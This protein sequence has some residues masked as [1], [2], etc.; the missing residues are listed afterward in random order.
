M[1]ISTNYA[2]PVQV[3]GYSCRNCT[4]VAY[5]KRGV[6]P[7]HPKSGPYGVN[8]ATDPS[9]KADAVHLGGRLAGLDISSVSAGAEV[10]PKGTQ[11]NVCV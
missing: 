8:A 5:A 6:D 11:L 3:N 9:R 1:S 10:K 4:D 7:A 2:S